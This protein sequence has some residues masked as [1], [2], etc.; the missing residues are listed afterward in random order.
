MANLHVRFTPGKGSGGLIDVVILV[1]I[2]SMATL[3]LVATSVQT[4]QIQNDAETKLAIDIFQQNLTAYIE[5]QDSW[6]KTLKDPAN[7]SFACILN[8]TECERIA[9]PISIVRNANNEIVADTTNG[10]GIFPDGSVCNDAATCKINVGIN[11]EPICKA[12]CFNPQVIKISVALNKASATG[13]TSRFIASNV[14]GLTIRPMALPK[15]SK[16]VVGKEHTCAI[17]DGSVWCWGSNEFKQLGQPAALPYSSIPLKVPT[18][19]TGVTQLSA[20]YNHTCAVQNGNVKCWGDNLWSQVGT[21]PAGPVE[22][23]VSVYV[24]GTGALLSG[25]TQ[26]YTSVVHSCAVANAQA[27]C[28]GADGRGQLG[29]QDPAPLIYDAFGGGPLARPVLD[30]NTGVTSIAL[31][32]SH[33]CAVVDGG[34]K[35]WGG[36]DQRGGVVDP[37]AVGVRVLGS[38]PA[39]YKVCSPWD[40]TSVPGNPA[41]RCNPRPIQTDTLGSGSGVVQLA[42]TSMTTCALLNTGSLKCWGDNWGALGLGPTDYMASYNSPRDV[43]N[44]TGASMVGG[45]ALSFC[46]VSA[47]KLWCW[48]RNDSYNY[49]GMPGD[50]TGALGVNWPTPT[51]VSGIPGTVTYFAGGSIDET[52][53]SCAIADE[54]VYCFGKNNVGQLGDGTTTD[55]I[56]S[57]PGF[58]GRWQ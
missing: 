6:L 20:G 37:F 30:L 32:L 23:P 27:Y 21:W 2:L 16:V 57:T 50:G 53:H 13:Q 14:A 45:I 35:C 1:G 18:L 41:L 25:V 47:G 34:V 58:V 38:D 17:A 29:Y 46:A 31:G 5:D 19:E 49:M 12:P 22:T 44:L 28:W 56:M 48:G 26:V 10:R 39:S 52:H 24:F 55:K 33:T 3:G 9:K 36:N 40:V 4:K 42:T 11:W 7:T 51:L 8:G 54:K 15:A 43:I